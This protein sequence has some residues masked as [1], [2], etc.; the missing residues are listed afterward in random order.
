MLLTWTPQ[1]WEDY[2]YWQHTDKRTVKRINELLRDA[3]R[4]P[5]EGMGKPEPLRFDLA[6]C[7]SPHQ[8]GRSP[9]LQ[10]GRTKR[11]PDR[12]PMP[13]PLLKHTSLAKLRPSKKGGAFAYHNLASRHGLF[14]NGFSLPCRFS[15]RLARVH[16]HASTG[17]ILSH[18]SMSCVCW[19]LMR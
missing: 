4:N 14:T 1:A 3:M 13:L 11:S 9:R 19:R 7:W 18:A 6:G 17:Y 15:M 12:T 5:F 8:S 10:S 16:S 2:L